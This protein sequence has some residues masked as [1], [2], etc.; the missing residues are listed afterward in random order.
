M[1]GIFGDGFR[2]D[3]V[4]AGFQF[5]G[6]RARLAGPRRSANDGG[7]FFGKSWRQSADNYDG[8]GCVAG[9]TAP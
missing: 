5:E 1:A 2:S 7:G 9:G 4:V 6:G 3:V 8:A